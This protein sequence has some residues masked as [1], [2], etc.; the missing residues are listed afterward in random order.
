MKGLLMPITMLL[1]ACGAPGSGSGNNSSGQTPP[2][3][4]KSI[5]IGIVEEPVGF[6][7]FNTHTSGGGAQQIEEIAHRY[8]ATLDSQTRPQ[9]DIALQLP[10]VEDGS[11]TIR[12]DGTMQ[13]TFQL[14]TNVRW[15][16]GT[17][18]VAD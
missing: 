9:P 8:L 14:R 12:S 15:H 16:D 1:L 13:T 10:S 3:A 6:G 17:P 18:M 4:P 7:P 2:A 11:W 5:V